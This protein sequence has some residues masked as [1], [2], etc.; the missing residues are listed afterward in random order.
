M[1]A[2]SEAGAPSWKGGFL[3]KKVAYRGQREPTGGGEVFGGRKGNRILSDQGHA[4][5]MPAE[6]WGV[7]CGL[8]HWVIGE[9]NHRRGRENG[10]GERAGK[11]HQKEHGHNF[12]A[13]DDLPV[14][15][16][17]LM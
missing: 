12:G 16:R 13:K 11:T 5:L 1:G 6:P 17:F 8:I 9:K 4:G 10:I 14:R 3:N 15:V 2:A 7:G